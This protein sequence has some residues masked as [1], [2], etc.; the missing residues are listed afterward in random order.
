MTNQPYDTTEAEAA[1]TSTGHGA[2]PRRPGRRITLTRSRAVAA[3]AVLL[4]AACLAFGLPTDPGYAFLWLWALAVAWRIDQPV[5]SHL[6]FARDWLPVIALLTVYNLSRGFADNIREPH[7]TELINAD[8][9]MFGWLTDGKVP[10][11]WLQQ[12]LYDP[13]RVQWW[14]VLVSYVYF[15]HFVVALGVAIALW[16]TARPR[17]AAFMRRWFVL[18]LA[19]LIT[20]FLYPAAPPWW[21][22]V[23]GYLEPVERLSLRGGAEF[24]MHGAFSLIRLGQLA[25][26][27]VAAIPSL[28]TAFA[29]FV[30]LFFVGRIRKRYVA[31]LL[32][33]PL[34]MTFTLVYSGEHYVIDVLIGWAY[35]L[36]TFAIVSFGERWWRRRRL[37]QRAATPTPTPDD[38]DAAADQREHSE[39]KQSAAS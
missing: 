14:E 27:P 28:H 21:A 5:R 25:S 12:E 11:V 35:V 39:P 18:S 4:V 2:Q 19:G 33:Y 3:W 37:R 16:L 13:S 36:G 7:V 23:H 1:D 38:G 17:W 20:Y 10:T 29:L 34:A 24:G 9:R 30:V 32:L 31:I 15:S 6:A 22:A 8:L 26:N